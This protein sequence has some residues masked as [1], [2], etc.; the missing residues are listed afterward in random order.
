MNLDLG[1]I[2]VIAQHFSE[3]RARGRAVRIAGDERRHD[4]DE[5]GLA[6]LEHDMQRQF[7]LSADGE[8]TQHQQPLVFEVANELSTMKDG[9]DDVDFGEAFRCRMANGVPRNAVLPLAYERLEVLKD[10]PAR[11]RFSGYR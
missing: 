5:A 4:V 7:H 11:L 6:E 1:F 10:A 9:G 3:P 8:P 2:T